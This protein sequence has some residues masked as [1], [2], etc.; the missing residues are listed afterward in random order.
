MT[1]EELTSQE[2]NLII[3]AL[4]TWEK[5]SELNAVTDSMFGLVFCG[6][7]VDPDN[8]DEAMRKARVR[9]ELE[10][11]KAKQEGRVRRERSVMI[12]AKLLSMRNRSLEKELVL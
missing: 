5:A 6:V 4:A 11:E 12:Q 3:E 7:S 8:R 2:I 10:L 9:G 1:S